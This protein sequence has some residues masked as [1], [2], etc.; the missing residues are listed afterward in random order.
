MGT[1]HT[2]RVCPFRAPLLFLSEDRDNAGSKIESKVMIFDHSTNRYAVSQRLPTDG[3]HAAE[4]FEIRSEVD[5]HEVEEQESSLWLAIANFGDRL[6]K[7]YESES[8]VWRL[9]HRQTNLFQRV[10]SVPTVGATDWEF[11]RLVD[12][13]GRTTPFW[14]CRTRRRA[15]WYR[16]DEPCV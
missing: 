10:A 13:T 2:M 1:E 9:D 4:F 15:A 12:R 11:F 5:E 14:Q 3:A 7:R 16:S 6:G 8:T